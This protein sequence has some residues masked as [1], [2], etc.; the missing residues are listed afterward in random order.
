MRNYLCL[1]L[2][3]AVLLACAACGDDG[4]GTA[5]VRVLHLSPDAPNVD[6]IVDDGATPAFSN[7]AFLGGTA[8]ADVPAGRRD[9]DV[10]VAGTDD[11]A[12]ALDDL[13]VEDG[14]SYTAV[15]IG[16]AAQIQG[17]VIED[18]LEGI[19]DGQIRVRIIHSGAGVGEVD[20]W[21]VTTPGSPSALAPDLAFGETTESLT[22]PAVAYRVGIDVNNDMDPELYFSLPALPSGTHANVFAVNDGT[23]VTLVAQLSTGSIVELF[24]D[25]EIR[26]MHLSPDA[27]NVDVF[28]NAGATAAFADIPFSEGTDYAALPPG[29][30]DF[31]VRVA[32]MPTSAVVLPID[33]VALT[34]G[35]AYT[36]VAYRNVANIAALALLDARAGIP[37]GQARLRIVHVA[38]G[39]G[40]VDVWNVTGTPAPLVTNLAFGAFSGTVDVP[41]AAYDVGIDANNDSTPDYVYDLPALTAGDY[42]NVYAVLDDGIPKLV[43]QLPS[44]ATAVVEPNDT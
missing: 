14:V 18:E 9:I 16:T 19:P 40:E 6:V 43:L 13:R 36:A 29:V 8:Y 2:G 38:D 44:G 37:A 28:V 22:I 15:A 32:G 27:P 3:V 10:N 41:A 12:I 23:G 35:N 42:V 1:G 26:V 17:L 33:D 24:P 7:L 4:G 39:V 20:V 11:T 5:R 21:N 25:P 31:A 30:Y 34:G